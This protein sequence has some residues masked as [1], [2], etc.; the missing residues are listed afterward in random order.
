MS[1]KHQYE[2]LTGSHHRDDI[3]THAKSNGVGWDE[4]NHEG[5][6]WMRA[7]SA[8]INHIDR[9]RSFH[10]DNLDFN[11]ANKMMSHYTKLREDHK[12]TMIPHLRSAMSKLH[13]EK[14]DANTSPMDLIDE[15]HDH[16]RENGG[17]VWSDKLHTL[18]H[19]NTQI[20]HLS[21]RMAEM[22]KPQ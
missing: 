6:N 22:P 8:I 13:A 19:L 7:S 10:V 3:L 5:V 2:V 18:N 12:S 9:G 16:L 14:G 1:G 17:Q 15:A 20:R 11:T 21:T 4:D